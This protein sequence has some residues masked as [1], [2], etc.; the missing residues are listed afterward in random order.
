MYFSPVTRVSEPES[1]PNVLGCFVFVCNLLNERP[2]TFPAV[3][4]TVA[5]FMVQSSLVEFRCSFYS[6]FAV[7]SFSTVA[8]LLTWVY[9][10]RRTEMLCPRDF[11]TVLV[12]TL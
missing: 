6:G 1:L 3:R 4:T 12:Q 2:R 11:H 5:V 8:M 7:S 10:L 9:R